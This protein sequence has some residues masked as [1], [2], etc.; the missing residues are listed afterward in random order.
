[1]EKLGIKLEERSNKILTDP[2]D[3]TNVENIFAIGDI[4]YGRLELTPTAIMVTFFR[5]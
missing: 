5:E 4:A 2:E 1:M 3:R